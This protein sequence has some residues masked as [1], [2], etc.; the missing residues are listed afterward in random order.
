MIEPME[1][2]TRIRLATFNIKHGAPAR[3]YDGNPE[4]L[5]EACAALEADVLALQEVDDG[6]PRSARADLAG[7]AAGMSVVFAPTLRMRG[8][9]YG[10]ALLV[11]GDIERHEVMKLRGGRRFQG[12]LGGGRILPLGREP[13]NAILAAVWVAGHRLSVAA[14]HLATQRDV[15]K[16]QLAQAVSA[17]QDMPE[18]WVLMGDLNRTPKDVLSEPALGSMELIRGAVTFPA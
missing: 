11:R 14:T 7:Q 10:N 2:K 12:R 9:R 13:R 5:A 8:G 1:A 15:S 17:L 18:P 4:A 16:K 6:V 3:D